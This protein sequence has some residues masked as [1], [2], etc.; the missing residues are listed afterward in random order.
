M[1]EKQK[2]IFRKVVI[3]LMWCVLVLVG[4]WFYNIVAHGRKHYVE[5]GTYVTRSESFGWNGL[6]TCKVTFEDCRIT[7]I[8]VVEEYDTQTSDIALM[9]FSKYI[10]RLIESQNL[11]IDGVTG[12][13]YT[14]QAIRQCVA[15]AIDMAGGNSEDW[16]GKVE[17]TDARVRLDGYDVIVVGLG[18]SGI[19]AYAAAAYAGAKVFGI[20]KTSKLGGQS[21]TVSGPMALGSVNASAQFGEGSVDSD[22]LYD[23]WMDYVGHTKEDVIRQAIDKSG[24]ALD[25]YMDNYGVRLQRA[26]NSLTNPEWQKLWYVFAPDTAMTATTRNKTYMFRNIMDKAVAA[27]KDNRYELEL[28]AKSLITDRNDRIC[29]V[30]AE[31][32]DGTL[33]EIYGRNIILATG[34]YIG[35]REMVEKNLGGAPRTLAYTVNDGAGINMAVGAGAAAY[36][37]SV[38]PIIHVVQVPNLIRNG[39]LTPEQKSVLSALALAKDQVCVT[40]K[41]EVWNVADPVCLA[42]GYRYYVLFPKSQIERFKSAGLPESYA[43]NVPHIICQTESKTVPVG[44]PVKSLDTILEVGIKYGDVL[45]AGSV[46]QLARLIGCPAAVLSKTLQGKDTEYYAVIAAGYSYGTAGGLDVDAACNVLDAQG[47]PIPNL[48]AVGNDCLGVEN[49]EGKPYT[50]WGG[51]AHSWAMT[52]GYIAGSN[53]AGR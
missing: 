5:D 41:G 27:G 38:P 31:K 11:G 25:F 18:G 10:P 20:E 1:N 13:T 9:A 44:K 24:K 16:F 32:P 28:T 46:A 36:N 45:K 40:E 17:K 48:Y 37:I 42:P 23:V 4:V 50:P 47:K 14:S 21:A 7:G 51:Q 30:L 12:A 39:D 43:A 29:G 52:S 2:V 15:E 49:A 26:G 8:D 35:N 22:E 53:A 19:Y 3:V 34:G 6:L 33:Y